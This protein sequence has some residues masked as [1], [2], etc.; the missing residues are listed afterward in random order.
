MDYSIPKPSM[1]VKDLWSSCEGSKMIRYCRFGL[2]FLRVRSWKPELSFLVLGR[3]TKAHF[4]HFCKYLKLSWFTAHLKDNDCIA[5]PTEH[6]DTHE[7]RPLLSMAFWQSSGLHLTILS[8]GIIT[9][10]LASKKRRLISTLV[11]LRKDSPGTVTK[12]CFIFVSFL[13]Y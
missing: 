6:N 5:S 1:S 9:M 2:W 7:S 4:V 11:I 12:T 3:A 10:E 13:L 8:T